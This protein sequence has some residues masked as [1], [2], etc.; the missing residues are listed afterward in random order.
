MQ[1]SRFTQ[2]TKIYDCSPGCPAMIS[3][4]ST[5]SFAKEQSM[6]ATG[7]LGFLCLLFTALFVF[8]V[9]HGMS[10]TEPAQGAHAAGGTIHG[11]VKSGNM[12]I[13]GAAVSISSATDSSTL[14]TWTDVDGRYSA[15][16]P[17][18][19]TYAVRVEMVAFANSTQQVVVDASH[20]N[21]EANFELTLLSRSKSTTPQ[22]RQPTGPA[23]ARRGFQNLSI[24]QNMAGQDAASGAGNEV[25]PPGM[26]VPGMDP[27]SATESVAVSG[28][29][30]NSFN[31]MSGD[32]LQQRIS[33]A[34]LQGG[35]FG[36][37]G[38]FGGGGG[39]FGGGPGGFGGGGGG[40]GMIIGGRRGF[41]I[42]HPHGSLY[43]GIGDSAL[44]ASP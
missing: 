19:G 26:P 27:N 6:G 30:S 17:S 33:D 31:S 9:E 22:P 28:N 38:G 12:P 2:Y 21:V 1:A 13:P 15:K 14:T 36:A 20:Q 3:L 41:D 32:E 40:R 7:R 24:M 44:N 25:V 37:P 10:Q 11:L 5:L 18:F 35:G 43:Y 42:N 8:S 23:V 29:Q 4:D 34:R 39:G 16:L